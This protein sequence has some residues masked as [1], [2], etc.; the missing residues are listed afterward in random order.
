LDV[1]IVI[2]SWNTRDI[3]RDCLRTVY[4]QTEKT[5]FE[6]IVVDNAS[7]DGSGEMVRAEFPQTIL[8]ANP[9]N[10]GYAAANNQG[11]RIARGRYILVLNSDTLIL[12]GAVDKMM[13]FADAQ[14]RAGVLG[15][16]V[17][18]ADRSLQPTCF[19]YPSP[20]NLLLSMSY[21]SKLFPRNRF[22]GRETLSWWDRSD[23]RPV[24]VVT[25]CFMFVRKAAID[26]VGLMDEQYFMYGE[27]TDW[28]YRFKQAGWQVLFTPVAQIVHYGGSS[29][30]R[31]R[32]AMRLQLSASL[33]LFI[34]K[35]RSRFSYATACIVMS[36]FFG[37][38]V[39]FW[40]LKAAVS[41]A[42]RSN[43]LET[44]G[45]YIR[46]AWRSLRGWRGLALR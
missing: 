29:S 18:N 13:A 3:L 6:V 23:T 41:R 16:R 34:R 22:F 42:T 40:L 19:L 44:A 32:I 4:E 46:G 7:A 26:Q 43:D 27:E 24:D 11:I 45:A 38:R 10:S 17:L 36:L 35:H 12:D 8:V 1:S 25:G 15:C 28:C 9:E 21:L 20:L 37:L 5:A 30:S 31:V 2:V 33:L 39:P 14:P